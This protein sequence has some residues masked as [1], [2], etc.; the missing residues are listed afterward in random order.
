MMFTRKK[1]LLCKLLRALTLGW[2][3][4]TSVNCLPLQVE[5]E[6]ALA[7]VEAEAD[8]K[9]VDLSDLSANR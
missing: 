9:V 7:E 6:A 8:V 5:V 3:L 1:W 2:F 4:V